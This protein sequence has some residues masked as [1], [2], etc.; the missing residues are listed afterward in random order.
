MRWKA[1]PVIAIALALG[2]VAVLAWASDSDDPP[3]ASGTSPDPGPGAA[4]DPYVNF[5]V[6]PMYDRSVTPEMIA[7]SERLRRELDSAPALASR[8]EADRPPSF[9]E[10]LARSRAAAKAE[11]ERFLARMA[12][13][14]PE[15]YHPIVPPNAGTC[16]RLCTLLLRC[17]ET[18]DARTRRDCADTC[19]G[20]GYGD[21]W[22]ADR[23]IELDSCD[24]L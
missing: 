5:R 3:G 11:R 10:R 16:A 22:R 4:P 17:A 21:Q 20:G 9:E 24:H 1:V 2:G 7:E 13:G 8:T 23:M 12:A 18:T 14:F 6:N 15:E 19:L